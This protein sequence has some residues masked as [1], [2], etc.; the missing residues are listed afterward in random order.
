MAESEGSAVRV[1]N[2]PVQDVAHTMKAAR[3]LYSAPS[4]VLRGP[5]YIIFLITFSG[6]IFSFYNKVTQQITCRMTVQADYTRVQAPNGGY[7]SQVYVT[8]GAEIKPFTNLVDIQIKKSATDDSEAVRLQGQLDKITKDLEYAGKEKAVQETRIADMERSLAEEKQKESDLSD[9]IKR[10]KADSDAILAGNDKKV[11]QLATRLK[12]VEDGVEDLKRNVDAAAK[13]AKDSRQR[14]EEEKKLVEQK[15]STIQQLRALEDTMN[16]QEKGLEDAR[17]AVNKALGDVSNAR[18]ELN[19]A[20]EEPKQIANDWEQK[21]YR[22]TN[23]RNAIRERQSQ[24]KSDIERAKIALTRGSDDLVKQKADIEERIKKGNV[25]SQFGVAYEGELCKLTSQFGGTVT[26]VYAKA[27]NQ[28][29]AGEVLLTVVK[30]T[31][32]KYAQIL[33][34]NRDIGR[35]KEGQFVGIKYDAYPYQEWNIYEGSVA[36]ISPRPSEVKG[37]ESMYEVQVSLNKQYIQK[38]ENSK[39]I[40]LV[41]GLQGFAEIKTG[42]K[43]LIETIFTP[44]SRFFLQDD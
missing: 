27:G 6:L 13:R 23:E 19:A 33:V 20:K 40:D 29:S 36:K 10:E 11:A 15:L 2:T 22:H 24:L 14:W 34:Q 7:I 4:Y 42:D 43:R 16:A 32:T 31:E 37:Q 18:L 25:L 44:I 8:E 12:Q 39:K 3:L 28:V 38:N 5:I 30:N 9:R 17:S 21:T 41:L 1:V 35:L 26:N